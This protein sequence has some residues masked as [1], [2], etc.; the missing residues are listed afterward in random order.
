MIGALALSAPVASS[1]RAHDP[2]EA[3][4]WGESAEDVPTLT[5]KAL[6]GQDDQGYFRVALHPNASMRPPETRLV[7]WMP[8]GSAAGGAPPEVQK[9]RLL[10]AVIAA[11]IHRDRNLTFLGPNAYAFSRELDVKPES[12]SPDAVVVAAACADGTFCF[13]NDNNYLG[14]GAGLRGVSSWL[15]L[16]EIGMNDDISSVINRRNKDSKLSEHID[17]A[18]QP[19]GSIHCYDSNSRN[20]D[21]N[22]GFND[23]ASGVKNT[24]LDGQC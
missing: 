2:E 17:G 20:P 22:D 24:D 4:A 13:Y 3:D 12:D 1:E 16:S 6:R 10:R 18:D 23:K 21:F 19:G 7:Y 9:T 14:G 15:H 11:D 5:K 8:H